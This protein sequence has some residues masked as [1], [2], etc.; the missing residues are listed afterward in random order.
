MFRPFILSFGIVFVGAI[1][2]STLK[3]SSAAAP[4]AQIADPTLTPTP[5]AIPTLAPLVY[6]RLGAVQ[7]SENWAGYIALANTLRRGAVSDV[8]AQW[9]VPTVTCD[10]TGTYSA[11]WVGI[12]GNTDNTVEQIGTGQDCSGGEAVYYAWFEVFPRPSQ[13]VSEI[14]LSPGDQIS[15]E[16]KFITTGT[17][18]LTL[19]DLTTNQTYSVT[20]IDRVARQQSA[21]WV[22]E[23]P[24]SQKSKILPLSNFGTLLINHA[25][26]TI[27]G[28]TGPINGNAWRHAAIVM[29]MAGVVKA[30]P[31]VLDSNGAGFRV[32]WQAN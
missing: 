2:V 3:L 6:G 31:S 18:Q 19:T 11:I 8:R 21:E 30:Y 26:A 28:R 32:A 23:A 24:A 22:I 9:I 5:T 7:A 13:T 10:A 20:R 12:D 16:V 14:D 15:A 1:L 17:F 29:S 4:A 25:S 27:G